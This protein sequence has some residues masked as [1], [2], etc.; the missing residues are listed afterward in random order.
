MGSDFITPLAGE[1]IRVNVLDSNGNFVSRFVK[2]TGLGGRVCLTV[3]CDMDV[4]ITI[5]GPGAT[6]VSVYR[7]TLLRI[8]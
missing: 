4:V 2:Y 3:F 6:L 5:P 8:Y 1:M 7:V